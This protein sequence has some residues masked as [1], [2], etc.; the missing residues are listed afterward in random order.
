M[1]DKAGMQQAELVAS[2]MIGKYSSLF[3][4]TIHILIKQQI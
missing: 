2:L 4:Y 3:N 1:S